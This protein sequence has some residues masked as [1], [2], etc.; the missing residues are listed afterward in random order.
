MIDEDEADTDSDS[1]AVATP[2]D[3]T[4]KVKEA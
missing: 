3:P 4:E 1:E 2:E